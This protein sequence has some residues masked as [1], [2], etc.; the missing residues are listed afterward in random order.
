MPDRIYVYQD[1]ADGAVEYGAIEY[2]ELD[3]EYKTV[4]VVLDT[5]NAPNDAEIVGKT[6]DKV[7][8]D[9]SQDL[10]F[11]YNPEVPICRLGHITFKSPQ[12]LNVLLE[13]SKASTA[14]EFVE[15]FQH[16]VS[17]IP[18]ADGTNSSV[19]QKAA[20]G[21]I[22]PRPAMQP[23]P[24]QPDLALPDPAV[25]V[26]GGYLP[27]PQ[28]GFLNT[29]LDEICIRCHTHLSNVFGES[30]AHIPPASSKEEPVRQEPVSQ[31]TETKEAVQ[32]DAE[33]NPS[34]LLIAL[35]SKDKLERLVAAMGLCA[36]RETEFI[37]P[38]L[39]IIDKIT[40]DEVDDL[41]ASLWYF[42]QPAVP[43]LI[44]LLP[45][46]KKPT[47]ACA[48]R[49]L[50]RIGGD[51]AAR[52][53]VEQLISLPTKS[54]PTEALV[55]MGEKAVPYLSPLLGDHKADVREMA[56]FALGK[57]GNTDSLTLLEEMADSDRSGKVR[58]TSTH[59]VRWIRAEEGCGID[60]RHTFGAIELGPHHKGD[61]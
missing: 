61:Q 53:L 37:K 60:L 16:M 2:K 4:R 43:Y 47:A 34:R 24:N 10:R 14:Q 5:T 27:C 51:E 49:A 17:N 6:F 46:S 18:I 33:T 25:P 15:A 29:P 30:K 7:N 48:M 26:E 31:Q 9:G 3:L 28:C 54:E 32:V 39:S 19:A 52:A 12:G 55:S 58:E 42:G 45:D 44:S 23:E 57:I 1:G 22:L 41:A 35:H 59:A 38:V 50:G 8:K 20:E 56:V 11:K 21:P 40:W 36:T 13:V